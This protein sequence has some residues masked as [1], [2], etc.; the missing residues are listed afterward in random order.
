MERSQIELMAGHARELN[1]WNKKINLT[2]IKDAPAMAEKHFLDTLCA[3]PLMALTESDAA[4]AIPPAPCRI[5]DMGTGGGFPAV[6]LKILV[7]GLTV[8]MVDSVRKKI[9]FLNHVVRTLDL[10]DIVAV[11]ARAEALAN[12][13]AYA[14]GYDAVIS[15]GFADLEIFVGLA[16]PMLKPGGQIFAMKGDHAMAEITAPLKDRF[17]IT[18]HSYTLPVDHAQRYLLSLVKK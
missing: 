15:R 11:H 7:P 18:I 1:L 6:P 17:N 13:P 8:T 2:A 9:S 12:D 16:E 5:M 10:K 14:G 4:H 3:R